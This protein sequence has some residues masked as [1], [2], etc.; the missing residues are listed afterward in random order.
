M[1]VNETKKVPVDFVL[2]KEKGHRQTW[3]VDVN[4][5]GEFGDKEKFTVARGDE[6]ALSKAGQRF[7]Q[8]HS[9]VF[10]STLR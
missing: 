5:D 10:I 4:F 3:G 2:V 7:I 8:S 9:N 6:E 1:A